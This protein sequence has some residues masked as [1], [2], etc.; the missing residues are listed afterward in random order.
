M[1]FRLLLRLLLL[2]LFISYLPCSL[3]ARFI[4]IL[5]FINIHSNLFYLFFQS[6][7]RFFSNFFREKA[8]WCAKKM[9][10]PADCCRNC[11]KDEGEGFQ[12]PFAQ[13]RVVKQHSQKHSGYGKA[14]QNSAVF[15][16]RHTEG[17]NS[18]KTPIEKVPC[19]QNP[20][21]PWKYCSKSPKQV[22]T[23]KQQR[24]GGD[25]G[26]EKEGF[27]LYHPAHKLLKQAAQK[28]FPRF[29]SAA[30]VGISKAVNLPLNVHLSF[31]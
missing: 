9:E 17:G 25:G 29:L 12:N 10:K 15:L 27:P 7:L 3:P 28:G 14:S 4:S 13:A 2:L 21:S 11:P 18:R 20:L 23:E 8:P 31:F 22:I 6:F 30:S 1:P 24:P 5:M 16:N 19:R 26:Q